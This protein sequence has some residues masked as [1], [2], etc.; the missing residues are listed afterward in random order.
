MCKVSARIMIIGAAVFSATHFLHSADSFPEIE[1]M[2]QYRSDTIDY[3]DV[4]KTYF[5]ERG[6]VRFSR[7][8]SLGLTH[9]TISET[10]EKRFTWFLKLYD[11]SDN[12]KVLTG[13][14]QASSGSGFIL[15]RKRYISPDPF[16]S[17]LK[18]TGNRRFIPE[19]SGNPRYSFRGI[20]VEMPFRG[21]DLKFSLN[22]FYSSRDRYIEDEAIEIS[23]TENSL[24]T[25]FSKVDPSYR[26]PEPVRIVDYAVIG[27]MS[28]FRHFS[29]EACSINT[30]LKGPRGSI[31]WDLSG[32]ENELR[33]IEEYNGYGFFLQYGDDYITLFTEYSRTKTVS[34]SPESGKINLWGQGL[35]SGIR[36]RHPRFAFSVT[37]KNTSGEFT[38]IYSGITPYPERSWLSSASYRLTKGLKI[39]TSVSSEKRLSPG[40]YQ[41]DLPMVKR[42]EAGLKYT[43]RNNFRFS[44]SGKRIESTGEI[45]DMRKYQLRLYSS[46]K[47]SDFMGL[48]VKGKY[49]HNSAGSPSGS[50]GTELAFFSDDFL[51]LTLAYKRY[52]ISRDNTLYDRVFHDENSISTGSFI[53][54]SL[55]TAEC[56]IRIK[57]EKNILSSSCQVTLKGSEIIRKK[58]RVMGK[59]VF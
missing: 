22:G 36:F 55:Q 3:D 28:L 13:N 6:E 19:K 57:Q 16:N 31:L 8:S 32:Y 43:N 54:R 20:A 51:K 47:F 11:I 44:F 26:S 2:G 50:A 17:S 27:T 34:R 15:G 21:E 33:G 46:W 56:G 1:I 7:E 12:L 5:R 39:G 35:I 40:K 25:V 41:A 10:G 30:R 37:G 53:E 14:F 52:F 48:K 42:E 4:E 18:I 38:A 59:L 23:A 49:Q 58:I 24:N 29:M 9:I 45:E